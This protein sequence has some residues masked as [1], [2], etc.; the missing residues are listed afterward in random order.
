[1]GGPS[2]RFVFARKLWLLG[3]LGLGV[4]EVPPVVAGARRI[5][6]H[7]GPAGGLE[8][9]AEVLVLLVVG[10]VVEV[11][12]VGD[13]RGELED[14]QPEGVLGVV[15]VGTDRVHLLVGGERVHF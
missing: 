9:R 14:L 10:G 5:A 3:G 1:M 12:L 2:K 15:P 4:V 8:E 11:A 6:Q 13:L 7:P